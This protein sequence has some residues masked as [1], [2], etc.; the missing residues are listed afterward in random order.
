[1]PARS[2]Q[3]LPPSTLLR[4]ASLS[5]TGGMSSQY[6]SVSESGMIFEV[7]FSPRKRAPRMSSTSLSGHF[8]VSQLSTES[9]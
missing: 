7:S 5:G 8:E 6:M 4:S 2:H 9:V 1:M 3:L